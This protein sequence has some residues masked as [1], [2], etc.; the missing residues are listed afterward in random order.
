MPICLLVSFFL[1]CGLGLH[2]LFFFGESVLLLDKTYEFILIVRKHT[3]CLGNTLYHNDGKNNK[4]FDNNND[5][6]SRFGFLN[7]HILFGGGDLLIS[8]THLLY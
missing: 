7:K 2:Y 6:C 8:S 1:G 5:A 4:Q 3:G